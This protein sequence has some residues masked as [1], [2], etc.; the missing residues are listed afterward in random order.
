MADENKASEPYAGF[1]E[2]QRK[3][4]ALAS[5]I[6]RAHAAVLPG[7]LREAFGADIA[8]AE[9]YILQPVTLGLLMNLER[10]KSPLLETVRIFREVLAEH[11]RLNG[12]GSSLDKPEAAPGGNPNGIS[13]DSPSAKSAMEGIFEIIN[14]RVSKLPYEEEQVT[15]TIF[16]FTQPPKRVRK[17]LNE[18]RDKFRETAME[19]LGDRLPPKKLVALEHACAQ[20]YIMSFATLIAYEAPPPE[21]GE[22]VF[23]RPS[24]SGRTDSAG[25]SK[26]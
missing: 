5:E 11:A 7:A 9:G 10:I 20:H 14:E 1:N 16:V 22:A 21:N 6:E 26:P 23:T 4:E 12:D 19:E 3:R 15:E 24:A 8:K 18:G 25:G 2:D 17:L 13:P